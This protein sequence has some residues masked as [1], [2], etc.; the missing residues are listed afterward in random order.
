MIHKKN[1][2]IFGKLNSLLNI[3]VKKLHLQ[4]TCKD[5]KRRHIENFKN[6][7]TDYFF[8]NFPE[9]PLTSLENVLVERANPASSKYEPLP[10]ANPSGEDMC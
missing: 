10:M 7:I 6:E 8:V 4:L 3:D 9:C 2:P 5:V 1:H